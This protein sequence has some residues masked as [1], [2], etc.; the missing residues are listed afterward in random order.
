MAASAAR[1]RGC[2]H[3][4]DPARAIGRGVW[5]G[6]VGLLGGGGGGS[7]IAAAGAV[8]GWSAAAGVVAAAHPA[9]A[10]S[11]AAAAASPAAA[12]RGAGDETVAPARTSRRRI[13]GA[14]PFSQPACSIDCSKPS[15]TAKRATTDKSVS[16]S[17]A[18]RTCAH[19]G[20]ARRRVSAPKKFSR[21][22]ACGTRRN[23]SGVLIYVL[24]AERAIEIVADRGISGESGAIGMARPSANACS[25]ASP[26]ASSNAARSK[27]SRQSPNCW[28]HIFRPRPAG[29]MNWRIDR[30]CCD[31]TSGL[32][33]AS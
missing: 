15:P 19:G 25:S 9:A 13:H 2:C 32:A 21:I 4:F 6:F 18:R 31:V 3:R 26:R 7:P 16:P 29:A 20:A 24:L 33:F 10:V 11:A 30:F 12:H 22:C 28:R 27:A 14:P 1:W 5:S 17:K 8:G 23:N